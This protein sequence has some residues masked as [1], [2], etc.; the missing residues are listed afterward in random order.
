MSQM[1]L[2]SDAPAWG[3]LDLREDGGRHYLNG[4]PIHCGEA[5]ML[6]SI[7]YEYDKEGNESVVRLETGVRVRYELVWP[8]GNPSLSERVRLHASHGGHEFV[9][10]LESWMRFRWPERSHA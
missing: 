8:P 7:K 4:E 5:L 10:R 9:A 1:A 3:E 2:K 6:Q